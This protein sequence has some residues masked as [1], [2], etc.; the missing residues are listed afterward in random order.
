LNNGDL[1]VNGGTVTITAG[2][3]TAIIVNNGDLV[4][5]PGNYCI[6]GDFNVNSNGSDVTAPDDGTV[7]LVM[8]NSSFNPGNGQNFDFD[9][10]EVYTV[11]GNIDVK[12]ILTADR[13]RFYSSGNGVFKT[14]S[15][16]K[17]TSDD[18]YIYLANGY[19]N[20]NSQS[21]IV[22]TAPKTVD[23][24]GDVR[25]MVLHMPWSNMNP[26]DLNGGATTNVHGTFLMPHSYVTFNGGTDFK[27]YSQ[28]I[29]YYFTVNGG[30]T[31]D[32]WYNASENYNPPSAPASTIE[33]TK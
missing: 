27:L 16:A 8:G 33:L 10:L 9:D 23:S 4:M 11:N 28:I 5:K 19:P 2:N 12:G 31:V 1:K 26:V 25:G 13:F 3:Y 15:G 6:S 32:I 20:W 24:F 22:L 29:A 17:V 14:N 18:A 30:G 21:A 7:R